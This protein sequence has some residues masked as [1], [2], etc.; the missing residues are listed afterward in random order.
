[1]IKQRADLSKM[2]VEIAYYEDMWLVIKNSAL[3]TIHKHANKYPTSEWKRRILMAEHS[4][5]RDGNIIINVYDIPSFVI[6]HFVRHHQGIEKYVSTF[7]SDRVDYD[8]IPNRYT[9]QNMRININFQAFIQISRK[10]LCNCAS[11]E[12][13]HV[14]RKILEAIKEYEPELYRACVPE[15]VYRNGLC[16][17]YTSCQYNKTEAFKKELREYIKGFEDQVCEDTLIGGV[18]KSEYKIYLCSDN[19]EKLV[20]IC[21]T[22]ECVREF[23][24]NYLKENGIES[25]YQR[26]YKE[27]PIICDYGVYGDRFH[28]YEVEK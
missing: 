5:I 25:Y 13:R 18:K 6:T 20:G 21:K 23:I 17:E 14:W 2:R 16:P 24:A 4:P 12:T 19:K 9:L 27:N 11:Y 7:R 28:I 8:E 26:Y 15:C 22:I 1:M 3:F 10:R